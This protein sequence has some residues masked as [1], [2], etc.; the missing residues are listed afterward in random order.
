MSARGRGA[1]YLSLRRRVPKKEDMLPGP[2]KEGVPL[3]PE[4][5]GVHTEDVQVL[6]E[7]INVYGNRSGL[8]TLMHK[9]MHSWLGIH[10]LMLEG[11]YDLMWNLHALKHEGVY[12]QP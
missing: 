5:E 11:V 3:M 8:H 6:I 12:T 4:Q 1:C 9:A 7:E 10:T 2:R